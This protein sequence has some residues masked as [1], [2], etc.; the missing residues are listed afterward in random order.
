MSKLF[1]QGGKK[2]FTCPHIP[3]YS[4]TESREETQG[5]EK[6]A[7]E[8]IGQGRGER[9]SKEK[10]KKRKEKKSRKVKTGF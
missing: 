7:K 6:N 4:S 2:Y 5:K 9:E 8:R 10:E 1:F 3:P